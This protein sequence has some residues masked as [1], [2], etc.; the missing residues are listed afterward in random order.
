[1]FRRVDFDG[2]A[3]SLVFIAPPYRTPSSCPVSVCLLMLSYPRPGFV[4]IGALPVDSSSQCMCLVLAVSLS[5]VF[6]PKLRFLLPP[7]APELK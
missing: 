6:R 3:L 1:M 5:L 2:S 4:G 7:A